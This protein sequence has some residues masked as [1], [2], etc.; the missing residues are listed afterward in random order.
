[1]YEEFLNRIL[2]AFGIDAQNPESRISFD[3]FV[4]IKC[5]LEFNLIQGQELIRLWM[6][7]LNPRGLQCMSVAEFYNFVE[8][9]ARG[10]I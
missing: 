7:I 10:R 3:T 8:H 1:M 2:V 4:R 9:M 6:K 5:F